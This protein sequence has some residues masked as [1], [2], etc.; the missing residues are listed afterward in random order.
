MAARARQFGEALASRERV[1]ENAL[2]GVPPAGTGLRAVPRTAN[3]R[4]FALYGTARSPFPTDAIIACIAILCFVFSGSRASAQSVWEMT[5]YRIRALVDVEPRP[6]LTPRLVARMYACASER[7]DTA[8]GAAWNL[9]IAPAPPELI[10]PL[11]GG[12]ANLALDDLPAALVEDADA[13]VDK[14]LLCSVRAAAGQYTL[15]A[16]DYDLHSRL[17]GSPV[18]LVA[19]QREQL[20]DQ[21]FQALYAAFAPLAQIENVDE[22]KE[23]KQ[24][25]V[26]LRLRAASLPPLDPQLAWAKPGDVFRPVRRYNERDGKL[27]RVNLLEWTFLTVDSVNAAELSCKLFSG[28]RSPLTGR[29]RGKVEM[30]ALLARPTGGSTELVVRSRLLGGDPNTSRA[31]SGYAIYSHPYDSPRTVLL[32]RTDGDGRLTI[33]ADESP[34]RILMVKHGAD[35]LARLPMMPG[36]EPELTA[37]IP[38]DDQRLVAEG[39]IVGI[40]EKFVDTIARR[41]VLIKQVKTGLEE[42]KLDIAQKR[43]E[44]L[45]KLPRQDDFLNEIRNE[46]Q[47]AAADDPRIQKKVDKLFDD[48]R[49]IVIRFLNPADL[50]TLESELG[51][52]LRGQPKAATGG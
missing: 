18:K 44:E 7:A 33:V 23:A 46:K 27:K 34:L 4:R 50:D 30:L 5:P 15:E 31:M 25:N 39:V 42:G 2:G 11:R 21:L 35:T 37:D 14:L 41:A 36:L 16:R 20:P 48:T 12:L 49:E 51:A 45:R 26:V 38:D 52:A 9:Q 29:R 47:R 22:D 17:V 13:S 32:G 40:Q 19:S 43:M 28:M 10:R 8:V 3:R 6:E 1:V 24:T